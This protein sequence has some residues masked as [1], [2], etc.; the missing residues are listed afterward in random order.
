MVSLIG[1]HFSRNGIKQFPARVVLSMYSNGLGGDETHQ[2]TITILRDTRIFP[3]GEAP[4]D[5]HTFDPE[6]SG[7]TWDQ[8]GR[9]WYSERTEM[10]IQPDGTDGFR[11]FK[12]AW[13]AGQPADYFTICNEQGGGEGDTPEQKEELRRNVQRLIDIERAIAYAANADGRKCCLLNLAGGSP[14]DFELWK[15]LVAPFIVEAWEHG[16]NIYGR[17]I[18]GQADK[19]AAG[20][21]IPNTGNLILPDGTVKPG[22][23]QRVINELKHLQSIGYRGGVVLTECGLDGGYGV[24]DLARFTYQVQAWEAA[25]RPYSDILIGFCWWEAG[26]TGFHA[27]YTEHLKTLIPFMNNSYLGKWEPAEPQQPP[28]GGGGTV[29]TEIKSTITYGLIEGRI[30]V[31]PQRWDSTLKNWVTTGAAIY[32]DLPAGT[33]RIAIDD[34]VEVDEPTDPN[35]PP[36]SNPLPQGALIV[37]VSY[38]NDVNLATLKANGVQGVIIRASN[39]IRLTD[40]SNAVGV[41]VRFW[42]HLEEATQLGMPWGAYHYCN[43]NYDDVAQVQHFIS[44][45]ETAVN[46]GY[47]LPSLGLWLDF[48]TPSNPAYAG[49]PTTEARIQALCTTL[50]SLRPSTVVDYGVYTS[51]GWWDAKVPNAAAWVPPLGLKAWA[52]AWVPASTL[53]N[54]WPPSWWHPSNLKGFTAVHFWQWT[55]VGGFEV[56]HSVDSLDLNY[57]GST[58]VVPDKSPTP[59]AGQTYDT[60]FMRAEP[61]IWRVIRRGDGS[62]ED[63]WELPLDSQNDV[64]VKNTSEGEWYFYGLGG[65]WRKRDTS[66][67]PDP[68]TGQ[69]RLYV[70]SD[71]G[72]IAPNEAQ[73]GVT[74][75][76]PNY[77][78]F[79]AKSNCQNLS[80]NSG[81]STSTFLLKE[82]I[83]DYTFPGTGVT[84]D[85]LYVTVQTG[86][87]QLYAMKDGRT[88]GW[89]GGGAQQS[90]NVWAGQLAE[91]HYDRQIPPGEP[92]RYC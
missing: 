85:W 44:I 47:P 12:E 18:Y 43:E 26:D 82:V 53:V 19:D 1:A 57:V 45:I 40:S 89:V 50:A 31:R 27:N 88:L 70:F 75:S 16:G 84:V 74:Y 8:Y 6:T 25:L 71:G 42:Q 17:H 63:V 32:L 60:S 24:A 2:D 79:K 39:G 65:V 78:Q 58:A 33:R 35:P 68:V 92:P 10:T 5:F 83:K 73:I 80:T 36:V 29:T 9:Y 62:S 52:A 91:V 41:D 7:I 48:E 54:G 3:S 28:D 67:A 72:Q 81:P 66:P 87:T 21:D 46:E 59:P 64:R 20:N 37:D 14:G 49:A 61:G 38:S 56:G 11:N 77:V 51:K 4:P 90:N 86:E 13:D 23:P 15:E 55:S 69:A 34:E 22:Q 76:Y 30:K